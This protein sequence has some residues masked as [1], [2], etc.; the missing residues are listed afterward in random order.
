MKKKI[1][2]IEEK[3]KALNILVRMGNNSGK[4]DIDSKDDWVSESLDRENSVMNILE[5]NGYI[6]YELKGYW[7]E[8]CEIESARFTPKGQKVYQQYL[9]FV[10][11]FFI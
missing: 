7:C 4:I 3:L 6:R 11:S 10:K 1:K 8:T 2:N 5:K 9:N